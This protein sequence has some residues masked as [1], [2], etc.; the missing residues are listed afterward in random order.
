[1]SSKIT[2]LLQAM[3]DERDATGLAKYLVTLD[4]EDFT[5]EDWLEHQTQE[6]LDGA[7]YAQCAKRDLIKMR[8]QIE[9]LQTSLTLFV[10]HVLN[11]TPITPRDI[12]IARDLLNT[13]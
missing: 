2:K 9:A 4:R 13:E 6:L 10:R 5:V 1:M 12:K 8:E 11:N 3:L 7:G